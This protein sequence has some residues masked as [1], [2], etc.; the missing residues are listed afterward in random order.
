MVRKAPEI[1]W[2]K[3]LYPDL[4]VFLIPFAQVQGLNSAWQWY[5]KGI[6]IPVLKNKIFPFYGTYFPTR[7]EHLEL[8]EKWLEGYQGSKASAIDV[9]VGCG[10]ITYQLLNH[11]FDKVGA[12]DSNPN[13]IHGMKE[14]L[15]QKNIT[16][17]VEL[18]LG[19]LFAQCHLQA[20][21]IVFN[22]PWL[23]L[24]NDNEGLEKAMYYDEGLF[25]RF[26]AEASKHLKPEGKLVLLFSNLAQITHLTKTNPIEE[27]LE[28]GGRF[29]KESLMK[30][31]VQAASTKTRRNQNWRED[32]FVELW[33]LKHIQ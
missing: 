7:F 20:D 2:L 25:P 21:L 1:G 11:G 27:E 22:P 9:G 26:F 24:A 16:S 30:S 29:Q 17:E 6:S 8:L 13:A 12:T 23:P 33:V 10:V 4:D 31:K 32:E 5:Q 19:D 18:F 28:H 15:D 3:I 14:D